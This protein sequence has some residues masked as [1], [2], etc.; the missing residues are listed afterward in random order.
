MRTLLIIEPGGEENTLDIVDELSIGRSSDNDIVLTRG[1][2]SRKHARLFL[3]RGEVWVEDSGSANGSFLDGR[4]IQAPLRLSP[5][6]ELTI[7]TYRL[8]LLPEVP[9]SD[10]TVAAAI[11]PA[12]DRTP[13]MK[14]A[15]PRPTAPQ[16]A[17]LSPAHEE[18]PCLV[19]LN[20]PWKNR[21]YPLGK[22]TVVGRADQLEVSLDDDSI[23]RRHAELESGP[24]GTLVRD[25][26]S[27]NG[28]LV[29]GA[30]IRKDTVLRSGDVVQFGI[31]QMEFHTPFP[32]AEQWART[33]SQRALSPTRLIAYSLC[34]A[35]LIFGA[36]MWILNAGRPK[37]EAG[38]QAA[39][40]ASAQVQQLL[41]QC[42]SFASQD[43]VEPD[44]EKAE[45]ACGK[46]LDID[47]IN[48]EALALLK[49]IRQ[50]Q[51]YHAHFIQGG[52]AVERLRPEEALDEYVKIPPE[53][54]Y[55]LKVKPR[56]REVSGEVL[57]RSGD[58]CR[59]YSE[60]G[61]YALAAPRCER[62]LSIACQEMSRE[63]MYPPPGA[64]LRLSD[65]PLQKGEWRPKS[66]MVRLF[67]AARAKATPD[68]GPWEC[69][70]LEILK[71]TPEGPNMAA[72]V[73]EALQARLS[74]RL[75]AD[76]LFA[77]WNGRAQEATLSLQRLR[78]DP[79]QAELHS[80]ADALLRGIAEVEA[81]FKNGETAL[82]MGDAA[83]AEAPFREALRADAELM[84]ELAE[85]KPSHYRMRMQQEMATGAYTQGKFWADRNDLPKAC[86][87]WK[88]GYGFYRGDPELQR[89]VGHCSQRA[90]EAFEALSR[91]ADIPRV[92]A[93]AVDGDGIRE[94]LE[95][96]RAQ[97]GCP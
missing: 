9:A 47:P 10:A 2:V 48:G 88:M 52:R 71:R 20:G 65:G 93:L 32:P 14:T 82:Q 74:T 42:R 58:D 87:I 67:L 84:K 26:R 37:A 70:R 6:N 77:Y 64:K 55:Y 85:L 75:L 89:V 72:Q 66:G 46:A 40:S 92:A 83:R 56:I 62:Y 39:V 19:G 8:R 49:T 4:R 31:A 80:A 63:E 94:K 95:E 69:P 5:E 28:T 18:G 21:R 90:I 22:K 44:W 91:C 29:N 73:K 61:R 50:E 45:A 57:R 33:E 53:S 51:Q 16:K 36:V 97:L 11:V 60:E 68:A 86:K 7:G 96:R 76:P 41:S 25:L 35:L 1:G 59:R 78:N 38:P 27:A 30:A 43:N 23:S 81:L 15:T 34:G 12:P 17:E 79:E 3:Q 54:R 13:L 24:D